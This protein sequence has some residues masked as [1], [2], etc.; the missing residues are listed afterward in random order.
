MQPGYVIDGP[1]ETF[2]GLPGD[3]KHKIHTDV[4][5]FRSACILEALF[6]F[7]AAVNSGQSL[8]FFP[9]CR[10]QS[11]AKPVDA[12]PAHTDKGSVGGSGRIYL[13]GKFRVFCQVKGMTH[14]ADDAQ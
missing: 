13:H 11:D 9:V 10:L 2:L 12:C 14:A 5:D 4:F 1:K 7:C 6:K 3:A 8:Q